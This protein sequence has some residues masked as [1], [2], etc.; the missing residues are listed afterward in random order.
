VIQGAIPSVTRF[1]AVKSTSVFG[2]ARSFAGTQAERRPRPAM[3]TCTSTRMGL[4][5]ISHASQATGGARKSKRGRTSRRKPRRVAR[6]RKGADVC[7]CSTLSAY[8][9]PMSFGPT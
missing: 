6:A 3:R 5:P 1:L 2:K 7:L 9:F 4:H 8:A